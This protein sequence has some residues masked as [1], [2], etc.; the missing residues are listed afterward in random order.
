MQN[1]LAYVLVVS[2]R[3][4]LNKR[5]FVFC[6]VNYTLCTW[7]CFFKISQTY[8]RVLVAW[9]ARLEYLSV[10]NTWNLSIFVKAVVKSR[11][12]SLVLQTSLVQNILLFT[13]SSKYFLYMFAWFI[14]L[15]LFSLILSRLAC[16]CWFIYDLLSGASFSYDS[17]WR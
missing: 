3:F 17:Q 11:S 15:M 4:Y 5:N 6:A 8:L 7:V 1:L 10:E 9:M 14:F 2:E 12:C 13:L 16:E